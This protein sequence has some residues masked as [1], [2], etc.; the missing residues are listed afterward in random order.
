MDNFV[1]ENLGPIAKAEVDFG[2]LTILTGPQA[3]G[4]TLFLETFALN[5]NMMY[6]AY[7]FVKSNSIGAADDFLDY[8]YGENL[9]NIIQDNT[10]FALCHS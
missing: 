2:D 9:H 4:K 10:S 1:V 6:I 5:L 8:Y 3:S 7:D